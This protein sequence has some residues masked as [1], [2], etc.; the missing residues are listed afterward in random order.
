MNSA[1][2]NVELQAKLGPVLVRRR[3]IIGLW[4]IRLRGWIVHLRR[5]VV[6]RGWLLIVIGRPATAKEEAKTTAAVV[7]P[8]IASVTTIAAAIA[9]VPAIAPILPILTSTALVA[10]LPVLA[11]PIRFAASVGVFRM[12]GNQWNGRHEGS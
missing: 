8:T 9:A 5:W 12:G 6:V 3:R 4:V 1:Q 7:I 2:R 11:L 10:A